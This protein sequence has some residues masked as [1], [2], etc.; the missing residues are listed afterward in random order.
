MNLYPWKYL[1]SHLWNSV[2]FTAT[3]T[4]FHSN[5]NYSIWLKSVLIGFKLVRMMDEILPP[6]IIRVR[7]LLN[8]SIAAIEQDEKFYM[9]FQIWIICF[10]VFLGHKPNTILNTF[11][12]IKW[13]P[14]LL[15][16]F[17]L[18]CRNWNDEFEIGARI[19]RS[20]EVK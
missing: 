1:K 16:Q 4:I 12:N 14:N 11:Y 2:K 3:K 7:I 17:T 19:F 15:T 5:G 6:I 8:L 13:Q 18:N 9:A 20:I 10:Q